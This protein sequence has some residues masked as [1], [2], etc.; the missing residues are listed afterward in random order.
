M[1]A[2][3]GCFPTF[4]R[5][6]SSSR[7]EWPTLALAAVIYGGWCS[8]TYWHAALSWPL[9]AA[10]GGWLIAWHG[11]LQH[12]AIHGHPTPW[13]RLNTLV[14]GCPLSLWLPYPLYR[15]DHLEHHATEAL[16]LPA[17]DPETQY[18]APAQ[19]RGAR[20]DNALSQLTRTLLGRLTLGP[21]ILIGRFLVV[22]ARH[23]ARVRTHR[24]AWAVHALL[25]GCLLAWVCVACRMSVADYLLSFVYPGAALTLL[26]AFAEHRAHPERRCRVAIVEKAP[27]LGLLFLFNNL[28]ALHHERPG[29][30][31]YRLP[32]AYRAAR[33]RLLEENG[34]LVYAGYG[35]VAA[36]FLLRPHDRLI[37]PALAQG[38][39]R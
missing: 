22:E 1:V 25:V 24:L 2:P 6:R 16:T 27:V 21:A 14:A 26:R 10:C 29:L 19:S 13:R 17:A 15:A 8:V 37:H 35:Q 28:H 7:F 31:W 36:R 18:R 11:S 20:L 32:R 33:A 5:R 12:E 9:R 3:A 34:G 4:E 30:A 38:S 39:S 23:I